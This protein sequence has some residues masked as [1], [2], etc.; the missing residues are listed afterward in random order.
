MRCYKC[1][2]VLT[3]HDFCIKCG[4]DVSIYKVVVKASNSYYNL[5]LAKAKVRDLTGAITA[6][7]SSLDLNRNN[8]KAR[9]LLGLVYYEIGEVALAVSE[10]V[11]SL[12]LKQDRNV[13]EVYLRKVKSSPNKLEEMNQAIKKYNQAIAKAKEGGDDVAIIQL[14]KVV[15]NHPNFLKAGLFLSLLYM[16][17]GE[18]DK[19]LKILNKI[20]KVDRNNTLALNYIKEITTDDT[21]TAK[22]SDEEY[23]KNPKK[24][25]LSGNDIIAP[26]NNYREPSSGVL[27]VVY[28]LIGVII[29]AALVWFLIMPSKI[30]TTQDDNTEKLR[31]YSEKLSSYSVDINTLED[32]NEELEEELEMA[33]SELAEYTGESSDAAMYAKL[34]EAVSSYL[35]NDY[36]SAATSLALIDVTQLP[37]DLAKDIYTTLE[38]ECSGG[39][40]TFSIAGINAYNQKNYIDAVKYLLRAYNL[41]D[42]NVDTVYYLALSYYEVSD[43]KN[44]EIYVGIMNEKFADSTQAALLSEY[45]AKNVEQDEE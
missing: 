16:K 24:K 10:W 7:K 39:A 15:A 12:N 19:A 45:I 5:G 27:T 14:K 23:Y 35:A 32:K 11:I 8:V 3:D 26:R 38:E 25:A 41:D 40:N 37:T 36:D 29:G 43:E 21:V 4:A 30:S 17:K 33:Q 9:N 34:I 18:D 20:L 42:G 13:A 1:N 2:S 22:T 28:I 44:A 31:E 6:L